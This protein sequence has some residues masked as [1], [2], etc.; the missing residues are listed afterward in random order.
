MQLWIRYLFCSSLILQVK[1]GLFYYIQKQGD[2]KSHDP[3]AKLLEA[4]QVSLWYQQGETH[5]RLHYTG[6]CTEYNQ[7]H[8][9]LCMALSASMAPRSPVGAWQML[10]PSE[11]HSCVLRCVGSAAAE[12]HPSLLGYLALSTPELPAKAS[13]RDA[14]LERQSSLR[15]H[16]GNVLS[17]TFSSSQERWKEL[18]PCQGK[19]LNWHDNS[20]IKQLSASAFGNLNCIFSHSFSCPGSF[21]IAVKKTFKLALFSSFIKATVFSMFVLI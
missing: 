16:K 12:Q 10:R 17:L 15:V 11:D 19:G 8:S 1:I 20:G 5:F 18:N 9:E 2:Q 6:M 7:K 14:F 4:H 3:R 21:R 13:S